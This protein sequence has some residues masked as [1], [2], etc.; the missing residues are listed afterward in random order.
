MK[1]RLV[2]FDVDGT[3]V[4]NVVYSWD[5]FHDHFKVDMKRRENA[6][7]QF[8]EGK[9]SYEE[10]ALHDISLWR[11]KGAKKTDFVDAIRHLKLMEGATETIREL[12]KRNLKLAIISGSVDIILDSLMPDYT[13]YFDDVFLNR[14]V[15]D[16][17]GRIADIKI[18]PFDIYGKAEAMKIVAKRENL[19]LDE[20]VFIGDHRND[21]P[22][23]KECG[24]SIAFD[25]KDDEL[26]KIADVVI[27]KKDL[28]EVLRHI[29]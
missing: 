13:K 20:C 5:I 18:T 17:N 29:I 4:D 21:I 7:K 27:E 14:L 15:F 16:K 26:R 9:I 24:L 25:P 3:L 22:V 1:Y 28:R 19:R 6:R 23:M 12:R 8:F 10:W 2:C 11:E